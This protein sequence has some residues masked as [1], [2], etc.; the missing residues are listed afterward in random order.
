MEE[1]M[2][3]IAEYLDSTKKIVSKGELKK[4]LR[5]E[6]EQTEIFDRALNALVEN[7]RLF[8]NG[9]NQYESFKNRPYLTSGILLSN[10]EGNTYIRCDNKYNITILTFF[11]IF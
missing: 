3:Y 4:L 11:S 2:D 9:K 1:L 10:K 8:L 5:I 6:H 7:G